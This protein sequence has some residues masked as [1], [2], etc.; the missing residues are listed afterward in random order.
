MENIGL[1]FYTL[2][3]CFFFASAVMFLIDLNSAEKDL[4]NIARKLLIAGFAALTILI[5]GRGITY[6][7]APLYTFHET[8]LILTWTAALVPIFL[9]RTYSFRS[10]YHFS[11]PLLFLILFFAFFV[12]PERVELLPGIKS[13]WLFTHIVTVIIAYGTFAMAFVTSL[14]YLLV[15]NQLKKKKFSTI[16]QKLPSLDA[17]DLYIH[18]LV[19]VGFFLLTISIILGAIWAQ[20]VWGAYWRWEPKEIWSLVTWIIYAAYL[21]T[22]LASGWQGRKVAMLNSFGFATVLFNYVVVRFIFASGMHQYPFY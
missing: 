21:H 9:D 18:K 16:T 14:M 19:S 7:Y 10:I 12:S 4:F 2:T 1:A 15:D 5:I 20:N 6:G 13:F 3:I 17:L 8:L 22:R 11:A